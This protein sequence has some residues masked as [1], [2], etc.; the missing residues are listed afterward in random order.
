MTIKAE[1]VEGLEITGDH[2][3]IIVRFEERGSEKKGLNLHRE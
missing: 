1:K 2:N 3:C